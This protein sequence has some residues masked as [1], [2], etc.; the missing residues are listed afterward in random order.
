MGAFSEEIYALRVEKY[1]KYFVDFLNAN[2]FQNNQE[3]FRAF[4]SEETLFQRSIRVMSL[5]ELYKE[6][7]V[8]YSE[9]FSFNKTVL[10]EEA[11]LKFKYFQ[12]QTDKYDPEFFKL[13]TKEQIREITVAKF[14]SYRDQGKLIQQLGGILLA[15]ELPPIVKAEMYGNQLLIMWPWIRKEASERNP[16]YNGAKPP[17]VKLVAPMID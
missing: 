5:Y 17:K 13:I 10:E 3:L 12:E 7:R 16:E 6:G 4:S 9:D 11:L 15:D 8:P 2:R 14:R 1:K